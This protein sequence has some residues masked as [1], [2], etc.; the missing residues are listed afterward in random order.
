MAEKEEVKHIGTKT[1]G[2]LIGIVLGF[3]WTILVFFW[4][5]LPDLGSSDPISIWKVANWAFIFVVLIFVVPALVFIAQ[6]FW[7]YAHTV[8][9]QIG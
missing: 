9:E 5:W 7:K 8:G 6:L 3:I 4:S 1:L 2:M